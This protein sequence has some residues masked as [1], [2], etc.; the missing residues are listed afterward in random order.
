MVNLWINLWLASRHKFKNKMNK[1]SKSLMKLARSRKHKEDTDYQYQK[2][3]SE[4][5]T[6]L[7]ETKE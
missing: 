2:W 7:L 6:D 4:I 1:L 5:R 3:K